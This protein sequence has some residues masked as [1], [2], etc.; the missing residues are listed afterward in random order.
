MANLG[1]FAG[2][3]AIGWLTDLTGTYVAGILLLVAS[4]ILSGA[5]LVRLRT[6]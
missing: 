1:G 4:A 2:P 6:R 5:V 3:Y